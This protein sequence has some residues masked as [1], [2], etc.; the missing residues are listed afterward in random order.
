MTEDMFESMAER[1]KA[2]I[3]KE[4]AYSYVAFIPNDTKK[5]ISKMKSNISL[6]DR[7]FL[8]QDLQKAVGKRLIF[9]YD[10]LNS[11]LE[12]TAQIFMMS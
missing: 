5:V 1:L 6:N 11:N 7:K 8:E 2:D 12:N 10:I 3:S 9:P 4:I